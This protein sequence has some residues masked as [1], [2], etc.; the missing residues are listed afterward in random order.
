[1]I[2]RYE[3]LYVKSQIKKIQESLDI[4][5]MG[6]Y[7]KQDPRYETYRQ[8]LLW[9]EFNQL[10][11]GRQ[12]EIRAMWAAYY[13]KCSQSPAGKRFWEAKN[14]GL[15]K[16]T[17]K[18]MDLANEAK[19]D[20]ELKLTKNIPRPGEFD[21]DELNRKMHWIRDMQKEKEILVA[22]YNEYKDVYE[23]KENQEDLGGRQG[24]MG[25]L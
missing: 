24:M 9:K 7:D 17:R 10:P 18:V 20:L 25:V 19:L 6:V 4:L 2:S 12:E 8:Y 5:V 13:T 3:F 22:Q 16:D 21:P 15:R 11:W 14:A 1:M 23:K